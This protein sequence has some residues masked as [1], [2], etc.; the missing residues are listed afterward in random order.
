M[1]LIP[2]GI[3][4]F[5]AWKD[6]HELTYQIKLVLVGSFPG[7]PDTDTFEVSSLTYDSVQGILAELVKT[8][9]CRRV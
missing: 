1:P 5:P 6:Q 8:G 7:S 4:G 2:M 9:G 3:Q